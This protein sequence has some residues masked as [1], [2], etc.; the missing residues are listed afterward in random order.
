MSDVQRSLTC[1]IEIGNG[2]DLSTENSFDPQVRNQQ[3]TVKA[4]LSENEDGGRGGARRVKRSIIKA[5][6]VLGES[7]EE[8]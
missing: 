2:D 4:E 5:M 7:N 8:N 6:T 3:I 1:L